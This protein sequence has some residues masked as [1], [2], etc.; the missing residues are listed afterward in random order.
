ML[1]PGEPVPGLELPLTIAA[2]FDLARQKPRHFTVLVF[3]RGSHCPI[4][5]RDLEEIGARLEDDHRRGS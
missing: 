4:S 3:Y 2:G 1:V 5:R